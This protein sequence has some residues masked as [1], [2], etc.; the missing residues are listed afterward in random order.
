MEVLILTI[1]ICCN[2]RIFYWIIVEKQILL[3]LM[4]KTCG[5]RSER[6]QQLAL[7]LATPFVALIGKLEV[8]FVELDADLRKWAIIILFLCLANKAECD[9]NSA[10]L[11]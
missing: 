9:V 6:L 1:V 4:E 10:C 7:V 11:K 5:F 3:N 2:Y 8:P